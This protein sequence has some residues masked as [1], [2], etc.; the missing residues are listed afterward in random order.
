MMML[1]MCYEQYEEQLAYTQIGLSILN[2]KG[3]NH[4]TKFSIKKSLL[5]E[6]DEYYTI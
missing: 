3:H 6:E 1:V 2:S 5:E 4:L